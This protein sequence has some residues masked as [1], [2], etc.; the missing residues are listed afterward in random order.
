MNRS[1]LSVALWLT[2]T[3][4]T[5]AEAPPVYTVADLG[6]LS[7][8]S[9]VTDL[10]DAG[11]V[12]G[13]IYERS[14]YRAFLW[15]PH[16]ALGLDTGMH[17]LGALADGASARARAIDDAGRVVGSSRLTAGPFDFDWR[18]FV[19]DQGTMT[20]LGTLG[21][22][23]SSFAE[24]INDVGDVAGS[25]AAFGCLPILWLPEPRYGLPA[26]INELPTIDLF[27][28]PEGR[29]SDL[30]NHG[31]VVGFVIRSCDAPNSFHPY[32][33]LPE[34]AFGLPAG[35]HDLLP[36]APNDGFW[37]EAVAINDLG[38]IVGYQTTDFEV[39]EPLLW[40][41]AV[42]ETLLL[43]PGF[44]S[45]S[46]RD[47]NEA[48][49]VVGSGN[50]LPPTASHAL[51]WQDGQVFDLDDLI[52]GASGWELG[53]AS[54]INGSGQIAGIGLYNGERRGF[55]LTPVDGPLDIPTLGAAGAALLAL[56]LAAAGAAFLARR[57]PA[58]RPR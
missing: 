37:S 30:N 17:D 54:A 3:A 7:V 48:G 2:A 49:Q 58:S 5:G 12:V 43:P 21:L 53:G 15:L 39:F 51:L 44:G 28:W 33:W 32:L 25:V 19:W 42:A 29:A 16:P 40:R 50:A 22:W 4:A 24:G 23:P 1:I 20:D 31:Q 26:G 14:G 56:V 6:T 55:L 41:D 10:N 47:L 27:N 38:E 11:W 57:R 36:D 18:G 13:S 34:P 8:G 45:G 9:N 46:A 35:P 52:V